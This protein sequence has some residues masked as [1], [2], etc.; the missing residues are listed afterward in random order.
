VGSR[1][2]DPYNFRSDGK[3]GID[4]YLGDFLRGPAVFTLYHLGLDHPARPERINA[5]LLD[6]DDG[7]GPRECCRFTDD[8]EDFAEWAV[9]W[10]GDEWCLWIM[11]Q[12]H[13]LIAEPDIDLSSFPT[14]AGRSLVED[15]PA[16]HFVIESR[17]G[18]P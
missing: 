13:T 14:G 17:T 3:P 7:A 4:G 1:T 9:A 10:E 8:P 6:V 5:Y 12:C 15:R 18:R 16:P 11:A 2:K